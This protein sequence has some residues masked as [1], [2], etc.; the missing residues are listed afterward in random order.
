VK[1]GRRRIGEGA[2]VALLV[3]AVAGGLPPAGATAGT[4][5]ITVRPAPNAITKALERVQE[6]GLLRVRSGHY[7][8]AFAIDKRVRLVGVGRRRPLIDGVC[9]APSTIEVRADD[10]RL[11]GLKVVGAHTA[12]EVDFSDVSGGRVD[13]LTL[14]D[15]CDA[16]YGVNVFATGPISIVDSRAVGFDDAGFYIGGITSTAGGSIRLANS[17]SYG[18]NRGV[19]VENSAGRDIR[20]LGSEFHDNNVPGLAGPVGILLNNS[21]GVLIQS[22]EVRHNGVFGLRLTNGSDGNV[23]DDNA[24]LDNPVDVRDEGLGNCGQANMFQTGDPLPPC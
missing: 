2:I 22:N 6:P 24:F 13:S 17:D 1:W 21:D 11:R 15:T 14:R 16:E 18:N 5:K 10:V 20:V 8:E 7:R 3:L 4:H 12:N 23:I 19:I 9:A